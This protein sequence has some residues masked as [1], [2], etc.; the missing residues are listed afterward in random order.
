[1]LEPEQGDDVTHV[2]ADGVRG[3]PALEPEVPLVVGHD[4]PHRLRQLVADAVQVDP[5]M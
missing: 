4:L 3:K 5:C 1:V 2:G